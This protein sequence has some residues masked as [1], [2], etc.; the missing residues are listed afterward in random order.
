MRAPY[1][2]IRV[3]LIA[4]AF[5]FFWLGAVLQAWTLFPA[6]ALVYRDELRRRRACQR[7]LKHGFRLFHGYMRVLR[8]L[9]TKVVGGADPPDAPF[10]MIA[11]HQTLVDVTALLATYDGV[12]CFV[13]TEH[14]NNPFIGR[15]L[16][17]AGHIDAGGGDALGGAAAIQAGIERIEQGFSVL[18]FPEGTRS[19]RGGMHPFRR[20]AFELACRA[21]VP[22]F[23]VFITCN[24]PALMKGVPFWRQTDETA[25]LRLY[26]WELID[27]R[28]E[29]LTSKDLT[30]AVEAS[31]RL[32]LDSRAGRAENAGECGARPRRLGS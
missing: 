10:V 3:F 22:I 15:L 11:N 31:Y 16:R 9:E 1:R 21:G 32:E 27:A 18:I 6:M 19:P 28:A 24:P 12:C 30:R 14:M 20:G 2:A 23:P 29:R 8:L 5:F 13:K 26:P 25:Q 7:V 4:S 17:Y